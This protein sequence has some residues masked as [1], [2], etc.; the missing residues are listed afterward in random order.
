MPA[1]GD[2]TLLA[3]GERQ[4]VGGWPDDS[5]RATRIRAETMNYWQISFIAR[6]CMGGGSRWCD[7]ACERQLQRKCQCAPLYTLQLAAVNRQSVGWDGKHGP[8]HR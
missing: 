4:G 7:A 3:G 2:S 6:V 5:V 1:E 8:N